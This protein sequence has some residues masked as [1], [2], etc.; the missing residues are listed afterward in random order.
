MRCVFPHFTIWQSSRHCIAIVEQRGDEQEEAARLV[1]VSAERE[2]DER[3]MNAVE[4]GLSS[5]RLRGSGE[6][7]GSEKQSAGALGEQTTSEL[8]S[9]TNQ[10][11]DQI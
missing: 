6:Q 9:T 10:A 11:I 3:M 5:A 7:P 8:Q 4:L 1:D 2:Q